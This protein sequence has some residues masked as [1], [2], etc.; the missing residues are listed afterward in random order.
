MNFQKGCYMVIR[1]NVLILSIDKI[2]LT[3]KKE[4]IKKREKLLPKSK[5]NT[6]INLMYFVLFLLAYGYRDWWLAIQTT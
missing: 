6:Q 3:L 5:F 4:S 2:C 1:Q